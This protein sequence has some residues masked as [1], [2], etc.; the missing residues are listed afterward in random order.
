[1][2]TLNFKLYLLNDA[3]KLNYTKENVKFLKLKL[4]KK[5]KI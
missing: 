5:F 3:S 4:Q 1:M 2:K